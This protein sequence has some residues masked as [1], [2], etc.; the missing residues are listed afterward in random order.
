M[1]YSYKVSL[2]W[3]RAMKGMRLCVYAEPLSYSARGLESVRHTP[4]FYSDSTP[5]NYSIQLVDWEYVDKL[6]IPSDYSFSHHHLQ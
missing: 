3:K 5:D 2:Y 1:N 6:G 4:P